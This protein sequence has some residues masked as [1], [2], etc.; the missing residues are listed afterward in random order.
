MNTHKHNTRIPCGDKV[1]SNQAKPA[2]HSWPHLPHTVPRACSVSPVS[3]SHHRPQLRNIKLQTVASPQARCTQWL[4]RTLARRCEREQPGRARNKRSA[5]TLMHL[6]WVKE[7]VWKYGW[8][9]LVWES[10]R[11]GVSDHDVFDCG[12]RFA[13]AEGQNVGGLVMGVWCVW[14]LAGNT[15]CGLE[16]RWKTKKM[17]LDITKVLQIRAWFVCCWMFNPRCAA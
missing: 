10:R 16:G 17:G 4:A 13:C 9:V 14:M 5:Y 3:A 11:W 15:I 7:D 1:K 6:D 12:L 2:R 8:H